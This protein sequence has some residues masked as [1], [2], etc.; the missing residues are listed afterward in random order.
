M[1]VI[2]AVNKTKADVSSVSPS[3]FAGI[4]LF[5]KKEE[6]CTICNNM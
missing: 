2:D 1:R 6:T 5:K 4:T 3:S